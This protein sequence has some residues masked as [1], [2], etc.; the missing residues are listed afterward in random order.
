VTLINTN[1]MTFIG[2]GSEWFWT[3]VS[4][5]VL[6]ITFLAI[7]RQLRIARD[8]SVFEHLEATQRE[9]TSE[10]NVRYQLEILVAL[11]DGVDL[12]ALP[13]AAVNAIGNFW[14]THALLAR[15][16]YLNPR[17][18][19]QEYGNVCQI[20]WAIIAPKARKF[21]AEDGDPSIFEDF[22]WLAA[23]MAETDRRAGAP[24]YDASRFAL[25]LEDRI[26][27]L[28]DRLRGEQALRTFILAPPE[29]GMV[30]QPAPAPPSAPSA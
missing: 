2:P 19:A 17:L 29:A 5:V 8:A 30:Q 25:T 10:R 3:A 4:G 11:R 13:R 21:R 23:F 28:H 26:A 15:R 9:W 1:G 7:Y 22:E 20:W 16:G 12:A 24:V 6:A 27:S 14:E 18:L